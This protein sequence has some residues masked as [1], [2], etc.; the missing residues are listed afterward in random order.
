MSTP[1][2]APTPPNPSSGGGHPA[3][4]APTDSSPYA[5]P[6]AQAEPSKAPEVQG[7]QYGG[8]PSPPPFN[9]APYGGPV[10]AKP[11]SEK[12]GFA[13]TALALGIAAFL[14]CW[15]PFVNIV[16]IVIAL[17]GVVF[18]ILALV[19]FGGKV[20]AIVGIA[21]SG[22]AIA[23]AVGMNILV[24]SAITAQVDAQN[25]E[26]ADLDTVLSEQLDAAQDDAVSSELHA[27]DAALPADPADAVSEVAGFEEVFIYTDGLEVSVSTPEAYTPGDYAYQSDEGGEPI[28]FDV[29]VTNGTN[30][31]LDGSYILTNVISDGREAVKIYDDGIDGRGSGT[32][33]PGKSHTF[34]NAFA[35]ENP[36]DLQI[37]ISPDYAYDTAIFVS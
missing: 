27:D 11:N 18:G 25:S 29:T 24:G 32:I 23:V 6:V 22:V 4:T 30:E 13:I 26:L 14:G 31:N 9:Q 36:D 5:T 33:L 20:L 19:K 34:S 17:A 12:N 3:P 7:P 37:E 1:Y 8:P 21:L 16:S 28:V 2:D 15:I 35:V 10:A